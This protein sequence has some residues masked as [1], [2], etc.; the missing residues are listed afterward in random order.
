L[1]RDGRNDDLQ[2]LEADEDERSQDAEILAR[3]LEEGVIRGEANDELVGA[4]LLQEEPGA[5]DHD[6]GGKRAADGPR[7]LLL[8]PD[9]EALAECR[10]DAGVLRQRGG[11]RGDV[12][13]A[14]AA[15]PPDRSLRLTAA[16]PAQHTSQ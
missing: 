10:R 12:V 3:L 14:G 11:R 15:C 4:R 13:E 2:G 9:A 8:Q 6:R 1:A 16:P 5:P 7:N